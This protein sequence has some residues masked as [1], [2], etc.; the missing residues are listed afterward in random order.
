MPALAAL[1]VVAGLVAYAPAFD[2]VFVLDDVRAVVRN[3]T[4]ESLAEA[5]SPPPESTVSGRP[6]ANLS[7]AITRAMGSPESPAWSHHAGNLFIHLAAA[8]VLFGIV[9]RTLLSERLRAAFAASADAVA[10]AAALVWVVHPL[11]TESVT[12]V[13]QRVESLASLF[14][15]LTLYCAIRAAGAGA[16]DLPSPLPVASG[17]GLQASGLGLQDSSTRESV[18]SPSRP[19]VASRA[20]EGA[21]APP[22]VSEG[23]SFIR[24]AWFAA[25]VVVCVLGMG[26]KEIVAGA[27]LVVL[28]WDWL[29]LPA[30]RPRW[31][32]F[33][34]LA[35]TEVVLALLVYREHRAPS[36]ALGG[37]IVWRYLLTQAA[38]ITHYLR[39]AF[40]P[41]GLVFLYTWPLATSIGEV[42]VPAVLV[43]SLLALTIFG[44]V[45]R[46]SAA[47]AGVVVFIVLAPTSSVLPIVTE[48]A[49]EHRMYLPLAAIVALVAAL[50]QFGIGRVAGARG[51]AAAWGVAVIAL[52]VTL[53]LE[54]GTRARNR[55]Y[56]SDERLW[57][58][59]VS[60]QPDNERAR[61]AYGSV[62]ATRREVAEAEAQFRAA[63]ALDAADPVAQSR[64]GSALAAQ[65]KFDEAIPPL[66]RALALR[67][68]DIEAHRSLGQ[69]Y[70][71][72]QDDG[73]ALP[74]LI[75]AAEAIEDPA[76]VTR[77]AAILAGSPDP[78]VR[79]PRRALTYAQR[80][81]VLTGRRDPLALDILA[82]ALAGVGRLP[83]AVATAREAL[84]LATAQGNQALVT[85]L[86]QRV[87]AY[88]GR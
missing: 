38:V 9:R 53:P 49:A 88:G 40:V 27:P 11:N 37:E 84:P 85:E 10:F 51:F 33:A 82:A 48:V 26:T 70:A 36:I 32:L 50:L 81:V 78:M 19:S 74:H 62:L 57:A 16:R 17:L 18:S 71:M 12:Y 2:G 79:D 4:L 59:T 5:L 87:R 8:L 52:F 68:D 22:R 73:R 13:V 44:L 45:R 41:T 29:F 63:V 86:E 66:E 67:P 34:A 55:V 64:L 54:V 3:P 60:K 15:L 80:A 20:R 69:I 35:A 46:H 7:F 23:S 6:V 61:V 75:R 56:G 83:E 21:T 77:I 43:L 58:D 76:L 1:I 72:R 25:A 24:K 47:F 28:A 30:R 14:I 31:T 65:G 42:A 39:L